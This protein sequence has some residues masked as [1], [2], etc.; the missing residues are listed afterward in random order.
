MKS[1]I[2]TYS[3]MKTARSVFLLV[4]ASVILGSC[5]KW[6]NGTIIPD[7]RYVDENIRIIELRDNVN[8]TLAHADMNHKAGCIEILAG[9]KLLDGITTETVEV[10]ETEFYEHETI[11]NLVIRNDNTLSHLRP[12]DYD[13]SMTVYYDSLYQIIFNS[14]GTLDTDTLRGM[15]IRESDTV[16]SRTC[17][18]QVEGGSGELDAKI[19]CDKSITKYQEGTATVNLSGRVTFAYTSASYNCHGQIHAKDLYSHIHYIKP[20]YSNSLIDAQAY[21]MLDVKNENIGVVR[22]LRYRTTIVT[23]PWNEESHQFDTIIEPVQCPRIIR[24]NGDYYNTWTY[25]NSIPGLQ[26]FD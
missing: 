15:A 20:Y 25:N 6:S 11:T 21:Y 24:Y 17:S 2:S 1:I 13:I 10:E 18:I 7:T 23:H 5:S 16:V 19:A 26:Y 14:N 4:F 8:V 9:E 12:Y 3:V 22:Y